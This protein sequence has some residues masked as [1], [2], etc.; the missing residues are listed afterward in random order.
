MVVSGYEDYIAYM[1]RGTHA[2]SIL[3]IFNFLGFF[4]VLSV[5]KCLELAPTLLCSVA[6]E[7]RTWTRILPPDVFWKHNQPAWS[8]NRKGLISENSKNCITLENPLHVLS[9]YSVIVL[10]SAQNEDS[11]GLGSRYCLVGIVM[12]SCCGSLFDN[13]ASTS[14]RRCVVVVV[15]VVAHQNRVVRHYKLFQKQIFWKRRGG[16]HTIA[17]RRPRKRLLNNAQAS[18]SEN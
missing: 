3:G 15:V 7:W 17:Y 2:Q 12:Q 13:T 16:A 10:H 5:S 8:S 4:V 9:C 18:W 14:L 1:F 11:L 6:C